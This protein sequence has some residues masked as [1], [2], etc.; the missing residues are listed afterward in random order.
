MPCI[1]PDTCWASLHAVH[2]AVFFRSF[3]LP[4]ALQVL[5]TRSGPVAGSAA[6]TSFW[7]SRAPCVC[8]I[9]SDDRLLQCEL[10]PCA[11]WSQLEASFAQKPW[12]WQE[13]E[14]RCE[15]RMVDVASRKEREHLTASVSSVH[16]NLSLSAVTV[17]AFSHGLTARDSSGV[18]QLCRRCSVGSHRDEPPKVTER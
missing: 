14:N 7:T 15:R 12:N 1:R 17:T 13:A 18:A 2:L 16:I 3:F 10:C 5:K 6:V 8:G 4:L 9:S 11:K